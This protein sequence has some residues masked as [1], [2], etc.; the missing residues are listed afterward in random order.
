[1]IEPRPQLLKNYSHFLLAHLARNGANRWDGQQTLSQKC[2]KQEAAWGRRVV[3]QRPSA[4]VLAITMKNGYFG[5][6]H[7][8]HGRS[9]GSR[10]ASPVS[11]IKR[12]LVEARLSA[13]CTHLSHRL[14][15]GAPDMCRVGLGKVHWPVTE[16]HR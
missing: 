3:W 10:K 1:M 8:P 16:H 13:R 15:T 14:G 6:V 9:T 11:M 2:P 5:A 7:E 12:D 4:H